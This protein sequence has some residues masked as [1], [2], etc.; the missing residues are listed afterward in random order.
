MKIRKACLEDL[1]I[2]VQL[3][4]DF[5]DAVNKETATVSFRAAVR[6]FLMEHLEWD[7][8]LCYVAEENGEILSCAMLS[9][10]EVLPYL[11]NESGKCGYLFN[12]YT[13]PSHRG[14]GCGGEVVK[15]ILAEASAMSVKEVRLNTS[16][17]AQELFLQ[18]GFRLLRQEMFLALC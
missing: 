2:L 13:L 9:L 4:M 6:D 5:V 17:E 15:R 14:K 7:D 16:E 8:F 1:G 3:R 10:Y 18:Q 12:V 11:G